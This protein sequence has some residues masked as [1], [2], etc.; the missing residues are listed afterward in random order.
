VAAPAPDRQ[1]VPLSTVAL[2]GTGVTVVI[3][4]VL[5]F[6]AV[7]VLIWIVPRFKEMFA[8]MRIEL[9]ALTL[10]L[11]TMSDWLKNYWYLAFFPGVI[12]LLAV[13]ALVY[14]ALA[15][16]RRTWVLSALWFV[17]V[18]VAMGLAAIFF[19]VMP[20]HLPLVTLMTA[21]GQGG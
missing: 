17:A 21:I 18:T 4:A 3:H 20:L 9:P 7:F 15:R 12:S 1:N 19:I 16:R 6:G 11:I 8:D 13:D 14:W 5:L 10:F 2:V